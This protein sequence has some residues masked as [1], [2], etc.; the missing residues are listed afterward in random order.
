MTAV[1]MRDEVEG[2]AGGGGVKK[3]GK[4]TKTNHHCSVLSAPIER[5]LSDQFCKKDFS[6]A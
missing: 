2:L 5:R 1:V 4:N 3:I 6:Q